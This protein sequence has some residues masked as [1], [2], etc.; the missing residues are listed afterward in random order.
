[1]WPLMPY[2]CRAPEPPPASTRRENAASKCWE[3]P[4]PARGRKS[5]PAARAQ[6]RVERSLALS[7]CPPATGS[8]LGKSA[9]GEGSTLKPD[10]KLL[11]DAPR[12]EQAS[13]RLLPAG[14]LLQHGHGGQ[15]LPL[16]EFQEGAA[17]RGDVGDTLAHAEL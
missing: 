8:R 4:P 1:P 5:L 14:A 6:A 12:P 7:R 10:T 11:T 16:E 9:P 13:T 3:R 2:R 15:L 17:A